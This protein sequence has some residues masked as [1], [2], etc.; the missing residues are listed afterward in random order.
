MR[1]PVVLCVCDG[2][3]MCGIALAQSTSV[4]PALGTLISNLGIMGVLVWHL[5]YHTTKSSPA[6]LEKFT[7]EQNNLRAIFS[8]EVKELR[9][10]FKCEQDATRD[11]HQQELAQLREMLVQA[12]ASMRVAVHDVRDT[13]QG[14]LSKQ[15]LKDQT[16][17]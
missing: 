4:D 16:G 17:G 12:I 15:A 1:M 8:S 3:T 10:T 5:W 7:T 11:R 14:V 6:M 9:N 13:A 2:V